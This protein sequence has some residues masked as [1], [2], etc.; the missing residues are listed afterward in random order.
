MEETP[1]K[2]SEE[3]DLLYFFRP[4]INGFKNMAVSLGKYS[5]VLLKNIFL[6]SVIVILITAAGYC[7]RY[8]M[9]PA[10]QTKGIFISHV[11]PSAFCAKVIKN[12]D[13][14]RGGSN[15]P[16]LA[17]QLNISQ[18]AAGSIYG[19]RADSIKERFVMQKKDKDSAIVV[20]EITLVLSEIKYVDSIQTGIVSY[21]ENNPYSITRKAAKIQQLKSL[22][23]LLDIKLRGLD[24]LKQIINSSIVP[25]S[26]GQ[27]IILGE[28]INP[29]NVV[30]TEVN[31]LREQGYIDQELSTM[32]NI[33]VLQPFFKLNDYNYP[34][35]NRL[36]LYSF[37]LALLIA[38]ILAPV[39]GSG[40]KNRGK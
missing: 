37:I 15:T 34:D 29:I 38:G 35:F 10:Y 3:I 11:M 28:P 24:S 30:Q 4:L 12:L 27:G 8:V 32:D 7:L 22:K 40:I 5:E 18:A 31:Y 36:M 33:E 23:S 26:Q 19:I 1:R 6:F 2:A 20:F 14:L 13:K 39:L 17:S 9:Q 25:R 21:L 16:V